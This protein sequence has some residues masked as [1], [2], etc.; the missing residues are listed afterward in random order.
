MDAIVRIKRKRKEMEGKETNFIVRNRPVPPWKI[1]R[2]M[3]RANTEE[4]APFSQPSP[5]GEYSTSYDSNAL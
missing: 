2:Y 3:E 1:M 4:N 5:R